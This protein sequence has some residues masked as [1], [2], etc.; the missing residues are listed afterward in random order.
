MNSGNGLKDVWL[1]DF[2][3]INGNFCCRMFMAN[4]RCKA[5]SVVHDVFV[6]LHIYIIVK[7]V[8]HYEI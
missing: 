5:C 8:D 4:I 6:K 7:F 3:L 2:V 1:V